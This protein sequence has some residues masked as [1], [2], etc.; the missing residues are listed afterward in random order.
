VAGL[1]AGDWFEV[2]FNTSAAAQQ[3]LAYK[4]QIT[5]TQNPGA[6]AGI[7]FNVYSDCGG[8]L[9]ASCSGVPASGLTGWDEAYLGSTPPFDLASNLTWGKEAVLPPAPASGIVYVVVYRASGTA[10]A[11]SDDQYTLTVSN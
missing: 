2:Q 10:K 7:V 1:T 8:T 11:C 5:V 6:V 3:N 4:P 9:L